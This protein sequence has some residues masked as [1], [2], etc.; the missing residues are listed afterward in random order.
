M[1]S[2][3]I[4]LEEVRNGRPVIIVDATDREDE[5]DVVLAAE[6][7]DI[8]NLAFCMLH[9]RGLMCVSMMRNRVEN[10]GIP[11]MPTNNLDPLQTPFCCPVDAVEG[12][13]TGM[14][15]HDRLKTLTVLLDDNAKSNQLHYPGHMQILRARDGLLKD[16]QGHTESSVELVKLAGLKP[17]AMIQEIMHIDGTMLKG[18]GLHAFAKTYN[19]KIVSIQQIQEAVY[20]S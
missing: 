19:I 8:H 13:T 14:S 18:E 5:G 15:V 4:I 12:T 1:D 2:I 6:K 16:R 9:A 7:C 11:G 10:L 20:G 17:V 3:E